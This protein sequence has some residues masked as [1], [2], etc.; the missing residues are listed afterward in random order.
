VD[1]FHTG[2]VLVAL[3]RTAD[4][5]GTDE[6]HGRL[7]QGY[8]FWKERM[9]LEDGTPKFYAHS[10][11]P[12]D[13]HSVA[14]AILTFLE[15]RDVD[16]EAVERALCISHWGIEKLQDSSGYFYYR[17]CRGYSIRIPYIRWA[18][19]WMQRALTQLLYLC[20]DSNCR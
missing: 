8:R 14:Q 13:V 1:N 5:L 11:Y 16:I 15:F 17:I 7:L 10:T 12:I 2:F 9:F 4:C 6:F 3:K 19:A 20:Y 18:Q